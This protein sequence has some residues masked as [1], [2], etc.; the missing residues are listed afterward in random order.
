MANPNPP[1]EED[2][3]LLLALQLK[4]AGASSPEIARRNAEV[5]RRIAAYA[6][7]REA[8]Q[9]KQVQMKARPAIM[10]EMVAQGATLAE[11]ADRAG[12]NSIS[13]VSRFMK[14]N[15][16]ENPR[17]PPKPVTLSAEQIATVREMTVAGCTQQQIAVRFGIS[18]PTVCQMMKK[19]GIR[20][21]RDLTRFE[22]TADQLATIRELAQR[23][24]TL[25]QIG[26]AIGISGGKVRDLMFRSGI[27]SGSDVRRKAAW[28]ARRELHGDQAA[29]QQARRRARYE[30][31]LRIVELRIAGKNLQ[32]IA[33]ATGCSVS[34]IRYVLDKDARKAG[35][36]NCGTDA[37]PTP[38]PQRIFVPEEP[39]TVTASFGGRVHVGSIPS[40]PVIRGPFSA[41]AHVDRRDEERLARSMAATASAEMARMREFLFDDEDAPCAGVAA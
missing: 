29:E 17:T 34:N 32:Q 3:R 26:D 20:S 33:R 6:P 12:M 8:H 14:R 23:G 24:D 38:K 22:P 27:E 5:E 30:K 35:R 36:W 25:K 41:G 16:I 31:H 4:D 9:A 1:H 19:H 10:Q 11:I 2:E 37:R 40:R 15:G 39:A 13:A 18:C 28:A 21:S 7:S